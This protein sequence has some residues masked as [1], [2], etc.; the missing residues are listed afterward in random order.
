[1]RTVIFLMIFIFVLNLNAQPPEGEKPNLIIFPDGLLKYLPESVRDK[2]PE[3]MQDAVDRGLPSEYLY[4]FLP[5]SISEMLPDSLHLFVP[6]GDNMAKKRLF[7]AEDLMSLPRV[8]DLQVSPDGQWILFTLKSPSTQGN[9]FYTDIY[10]KSKDGKITHKLTTNAKAD[11]NGRWSPDGS[12]VAYISASSKTPQI[13]ILDFP[14]GTPKKVSDA[15]NGVAN[16]AW[17]PDGKYFSFTSD[18]KLDNSVHDKYTNYSKA[19]VRIYDKLPIRHWDEWTDENYSHLFIMPVEGGEAIDLMKNEK[20]DTPLKPFGGAEDIAWSPDSKEI[21]YTCKKI[22]NYVE[23][24]NSD[25]YVVNIE[26]GKTKNVTKGMMGFDLA[27]LYSPDG[28]WIAFN[29]MENAGFES[30]RHRLMLYN[31]DSEEITE[32]S[33]TFDNWVGETIWHPNSKSLFFTAGDRGTV[34]LF[35]IAVDD[36]DIGEKELEEGNW[37]VVADGWYNYGGGLDITKDGDTLIFGRQSMVEPLELYSMP[38]LGGEQFKITH[39]GD[40]MNMELLRPKIE[41]KWITSVDGAQVHCWILYPP[42]FDETKKYPLITYCQGGPQSMIG[43]RYHFRWNYYLMASHGYVM[44]LPN[45]RGVPGFGQK[46][47]D[48]ISKDWAGKPMQD[49]MAATDIMLKK[50]YIDKKGSAAIGASA[51]GYAVFW[52]AGN[53]NG[54]YQ[55]FMSH[56]GVFN[57]ESMYGSTEELW[58]PN[59]EY[60]GPYWDEKNKESYAKNSPH[61]FAQNWDTPIMIS[62]GENDYRVPYTQSLEAFTVAQTKGIDSKLVFFPKETHFISHPQE[63]IIWDSEFFEFLDKYCKH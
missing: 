18:V 32:L 54:R 10:A 34:K 31:R 4:T 52:L 63:F 42:G 2:F 29:S 48:A 6:K 40:Q 45:R 47:N 58:F 60:G 13:F 41:E 14:K 61:R 27:P 16:L 46:W 21:A 3:I 22:P 11:Y 35:R 56:C 28:E 15:E 12:K 38:T 24:T 26:T 23:S 51:G 62:T 57:L 9:K 17:S 55:A 8:S 37:M 50:P 44:I 49:I 1:M 59:W 33:K 7:T 20:Y 19:N 36:I 5:D 53:H 39:Y 43:Q 25:I 30:D